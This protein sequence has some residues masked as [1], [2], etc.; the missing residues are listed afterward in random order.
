L[1]LVHTGKKRITNPAYTHVTNIKLKKEEAEK[2]Q[3]DLDTSKMTHEKEGKK[4]EKGSKIIDAG[5]KKR[6]Q[7]L[8]CHSTR[9]NNGFRMLNATCAHWRSLSWVK[10]AGKQVLVIMVMMMVK[11]STRTSLFRS[12]EHSVH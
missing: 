1:S 9:H 4:R 8:E 12:N 6:S 7:R 3:I 5:G 10:A 2:E 11:A